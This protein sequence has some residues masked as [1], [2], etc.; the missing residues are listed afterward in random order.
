[1]T[2]RRPRRFPWGTGPAPGLVCDACR[3]PIPRR[4][5]HYVFDGLHLLCFYCV[6]D[7][8]LH[9]RLF[10]DCPI[11]EHSLYGHVPSPISRATAWRVLADPHSKSCDS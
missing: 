5:V 3:E 6:E 8:E 1:M 10:P 4:S 7:P 2:T 9:A 11:G